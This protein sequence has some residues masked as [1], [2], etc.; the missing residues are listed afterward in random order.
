MTPGPGRDAAI[1]AFS[2]TLARENPVD[3]LTWAGSISD[4]QQRTE[5]QFNLARRWY[6]NAPNDAQPWIAANLPAE[7]QGRALS[8]AKR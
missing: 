8:P 3:A 6:A 4:P 1:Q 2:G 5:L 7:L